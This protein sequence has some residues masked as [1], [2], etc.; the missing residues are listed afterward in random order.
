ME[1]IE[2]LRTWVQKPGNFPKVDKVTVEELLPPKRVVDNL[3]SI[4]QEEMPDCRG[5][6]HMGFDPNLLYD[7]EVRAAAKV[8]PRVERVDPS[9]SGY[10]FCRI[11][12]FFHR[13][14]GR[15][16]R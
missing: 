2:T 13:I 10:R 11:N 3:L 1:G 12:E 16:S 7:R 9:R 4:G 8:S 15:P 5:I 6:K 14:M